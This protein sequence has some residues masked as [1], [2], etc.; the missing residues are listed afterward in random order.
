[1][2]LLNSLK[3]SLYVIFHPFD[4]FWDLKRERRG[5]MDAAIIILALL[6]LVFVMER[7]L[8]A[9]LFNG[10]KTDEIN[11]YREILGVVVPFI[12]WCVANW[13]LT[14]LMDGEGNF[15]DIV[16][17][18]AYAL[19]PLLIFKFSLIIMSYFIT[20][21]EGTFYRFFQSLSFIWSSALIV[22]GT[23]VT[24]Q[25]SMGKTLITILFIFVGM[26]LMIFIGL[27]FFSVI[28]QMISFVA[29]VYNEIILRF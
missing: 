29:T 1:M 8:T 25:Y 21:E 10:Y 26:G 13:C 7:Q 14:T 18:T 15:K 28:Q 3:Y 9:F 22:L 4:G 24:H 19:V 6:S 16:I 12:L 20:V 5:R 17:A 23:M 27:L 2:E 11:L